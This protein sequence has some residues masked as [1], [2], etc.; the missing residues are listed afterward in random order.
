MKSI[1]KYLIGG[2][3][4]IST[5]II[6]LSHPSFGYQQKVMVA[7]QYFIWGNSLNVSCSGNL[8]LSKIKVV[9]ENDLAMTE[10]SN[11]AEVERMLE[12]IQTQKVIRETVYQN[13]KQLMD[14]PYDQGKQRLMV[15]YNNKLI[16]ELYHWQTSY[17]HVHVYNIELVKINNTIKLK[18]E[19]LGPDQ[20]S[21]GCLNY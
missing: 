14:I 8:E 19:I 3:I 16:G 12:N 15:F 20:I 7:L 17:H 10:Y 9:F 6:I 2:L 4:L 1:Y 21:N 18:A 13:G 5:P 11:P